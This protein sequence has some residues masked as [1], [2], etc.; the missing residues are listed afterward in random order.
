MPGGL[1][2]VVLRF[3]FRQNGLNGFPDVGGRNLPFPM[4]VAYITACT[5]VQAVTTTSLSFYLF[6][7]PLI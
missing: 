7:L 3:K 2:E 1:W 6:F 5:T 4:P